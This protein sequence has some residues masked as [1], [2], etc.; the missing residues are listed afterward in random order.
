MN[1]LCYASIPTLSRFCFIFELQNNNHCNN[2]T[3]LQ[4]CNFFAV[5]FFHFMSIG[6]RI[7]EI[8]S[9]K[10]LNYRSLSKIL[11]CSDT[12][13][14]RI[15]K[16]ESTPRVDF[17]QHFCMTF[18]D[19]DVNWLITGIKSEANHPKELDYESLAK[20]VFDDWDELMK[21]RLFQAT[22]ESKAASWA[23]KNIDPNE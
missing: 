7:G 1:I 12:H 19:V 13:I 14:G 18:S 22:F 20:I 6:K 3:F 11:G 8:M 17:I 10:G 2:T 9:Q 23:L 16:D 4:H 15:I 21:I 5:F